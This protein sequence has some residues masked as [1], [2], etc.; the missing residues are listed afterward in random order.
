MGFARGRLLGVGR[1]SIVADSKILLARSYIVANKQ[2]ECTDV[3]DGHG[4]RG[5][6]PGRTNPGGK[7]SPGGGPL[8]F[9]QHELIL[10]EGV[11]RR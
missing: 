8:R 4:G 9:G 10:V 1:D 5:P 11:V 2:K 7:V 3:K 6:G